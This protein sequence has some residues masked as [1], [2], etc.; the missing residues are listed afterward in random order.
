MKTGEQKRPVFIS[1]I[2]LALLIIAGIGYL[3]YWVIFSNYIATDNASIDG[4]HVS[5]SAKMMGRVKNLLVNEGDKVEAGQLLVQLDDTDLLAQEFH[6]SA[7]VKSAGQNLILAK[8]NLDR[9][10]EDFARIKTLS[11]TGNV[12]KEQYDHA[13]KSVDAAKA[14]YSIAQ[15]QIDA[16][17]AQLGVIR[18]QLLNTKIIAPISGVVAK[19][20]VMPGEVVQPG[21]A[22]FTINDLSH[23][24]VTA[25][26]EETKIRLIH[27]GEPVD[28]TV[29]AYPNYPFKGRVKQIAAAIVP[30]PFS[31]GESA[32]TTQKIPVKIAL[33]KIPDS[34]VLLPGMSVEVKIKVK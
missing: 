32:K 33:N 22:I 9:T 25:N 34:K 24:W 20:L 21:Q 31:I 30:P 16:A 4:D 28:I 17:N 19:R 23:I 14:Q 27:P 2:I 11:D 3:G 5:V 12:T 13:A 29:D 7:S 1:V 18:T 10:K 15:S 6:L 8:V 26:F